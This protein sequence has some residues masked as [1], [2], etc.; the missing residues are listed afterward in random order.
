MSS[1]RWTIRDVLAVVLSVVCF[2]V[3]WFV[4]LGPNLFVYRFPDREYALEQLSKNK[5]LD[6]VRPSRL[7]G[8]PVVEPFLGAAH[9]VDSGRASVD[10]SLE[11]QAPGDLHAGPDHHWHRPGKRL[12][13]TRHQNGQHCL[14]PGH[15]LCPRADHLLC[16]DIVRH[17]Y[18]ATKLFGYSQA[19][20]LQRIY[21]FALVALTLLDDD[22]SPYNAITPSSPLAQRNAE[23]K[24]IFND[25]FTMCIFTAIVLTEWYQAADLDEL[26]EYRAKEAKIKSGL[27]SLE[28]PLVR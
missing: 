5:A 9:Q 12:P 13:H 3:A 27:P 21:F 8:D 2:A 26:L 7:L 22:N 24:E 4:S 11:W 16:E 14:C 17:K 19:I 10:P 23:A 15:G 25:A 18:W 1:P 28:Q 6:V 20:A